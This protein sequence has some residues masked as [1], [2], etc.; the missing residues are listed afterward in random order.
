MPRSERWWPLL[1][2]GLALLG[3]AAAWAFQGPTYLLYNASPSVPTGFYWLRHDTTEQSLRRGEL[4]VFDA[5]GVGAQLIAQ[6]G[7]LPAGYPLMKPVAATAGDVFC[8]DNRVVTV[9]DQRHGTVPEADGAGRV[10]PWWKHCGPVPS[11]YFVVLSLHARSF[12][13]RHYG[14]IRAD[15]I[16]ARATPLWT[17]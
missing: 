1:V 15:Q 8:T 7:Y 9:N 14:P 10:L 16:H 4:V 11:A 12:D 17:Y 5:P 6:R 2:A 3:C 13:S